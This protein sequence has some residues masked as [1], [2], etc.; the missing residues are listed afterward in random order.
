[1]RTF[2]QDYINSILSQSDILPVFFIVKGDPKE[3]PDIYFLKCESGLF[4]CVKVQKEMRCHAAIPK[5]KRGLQ[6][7]KDV[8]KAIEWVF[9][10]TDCERITTKADKTKKHLL[11]F[12]GKLFQRVKEDEEFIYYEVKR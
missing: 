8:K 10:N 2:D 6:A 5:D 3:Y 9:E 1:M 11:H 4:P 12:N 7:Y